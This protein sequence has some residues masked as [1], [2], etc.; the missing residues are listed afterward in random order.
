[1]SWGKCEEAA[2]QATN[3]LSRYQKVFTLVRAPYLVV[4]GFS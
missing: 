4:S 3:L 2:T 1:M